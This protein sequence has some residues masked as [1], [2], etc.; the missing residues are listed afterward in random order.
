LLAAHRERDGAL[1][2][3]RS[4]EALI[5]VDAASHRICAPVLVETP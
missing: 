4:L 5:W 2:P 1:C 3:F